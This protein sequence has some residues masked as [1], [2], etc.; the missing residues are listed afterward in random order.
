MRALVAATLLAVAAGC[1]L[2]PKPPAPGYSG[3]VPSGAAQ[4][5]VRDLLGKTLTTTGG[6]LGAATHTVGGFAVIPNPIT[7]KGPV[8]TLTMADGG[9]GYVPV[10]TDADIADLYRRVT[11]AAHPTLPSGPPGD[12]YLAAVGPGQ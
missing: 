11:G 8:I 1:G 12:R 2:A 3:T 4:T 10:D 5:A 9:T 7:G 6:R